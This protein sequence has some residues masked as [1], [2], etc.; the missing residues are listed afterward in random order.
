MQNVTP[1]FMKGMNNFTKQRFM[2]ISEF[3]TSLF[4]CFKVEQKAFRRLRALQSD[5]LTKAYL[6]YHRAIVHLY[7]T[8]KKERDQ[9]FSDFMI[10]SFFLPIDDFID[11]ADNVCE[12]M[13]IVE[14]EK[15]K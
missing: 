13:Q 14:S 12:A 3:K 5:E 6:Q 4:D 9:F 11:F 1:E 2:Q 10:S 7:A 8:A 15:E